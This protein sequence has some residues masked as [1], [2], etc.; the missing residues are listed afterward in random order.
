M[1]VIS[2]KVP[3][4]DLRP[5]VVLGYWLF[6]DLVLSISNWVEACFR[7]DLAVASLACLVTPLY[8]TA[9]MATRMAMM[10]M[11]MRSS[12]MVKPRETVEVL[13][14]LRE[15]KALEMM[16]ILFGC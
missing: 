10:T 14:E 6:D 15:L 2:R 4:D 5:D 16:D 12:M 13:E 7:S 8:A 11:T 1:E 9:V 3:D